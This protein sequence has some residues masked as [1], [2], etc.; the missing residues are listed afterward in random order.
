MLS[1]ETK[2]WCVEEKFLYSKVMGMLNKY[3]NEE[4]K[5]VEVSDRKFIKAFFTLTVDWLKRREWREFRHEWIRSLLLR[6]NEVITHKDE[7][8]GERISHEE[9][10]IYLAEVKHEHKQFKQ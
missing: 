3:Y 10:K 8:V 2:R 7:L 4:T 6:K 9:I 1:N 5:R